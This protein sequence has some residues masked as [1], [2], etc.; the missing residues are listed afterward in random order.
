MI[1]SLL[2]MLA[3]SGCIS[4]F[5]EG[6]KT[7]EPEDTAEVTDDTAAEDTEPERLYCDTLSLDIGGPDS[8]VVGDVWYV[9]VD[10][11][12]A[13]LLGG[14]VVR[15][16]PVEGASLDENVLTF[17]EPGEGMV[18]VRAGTTELTQDVTVGEAPEGG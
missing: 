17:L 15:Y 12:G 14:I 9:W 4:G 1:R 11:D 6:A 3:L 13:R 8:P 7:S 18:V 2:P 10:C 5:I 16:D